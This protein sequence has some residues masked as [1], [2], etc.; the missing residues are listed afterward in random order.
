MTAGLSTFD[1][2]SRVPVVV[3]WRLEKGVTLTGPIL[4]I[5]AYIHLLSSKTH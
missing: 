4:F 3:V 5:S 2:V 1:S